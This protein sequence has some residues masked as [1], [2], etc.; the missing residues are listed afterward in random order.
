MAYK[1]N[2]WASLLGLAYR[3][4][5]VVSGEETVVQSVRKSQA[6]LVMLSR[7][8]SDRTTKTI[9]DKCRYYKVPIVFVDDRKSLGEAIG[10]AER[11][12]V[13]VTDPGF[14]EKLREMCESNNRG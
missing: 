1:S 14:G 8:A 4:R 3:A 2:G 10:K 5:K 6:K 13:A 12:V 7:D 11:V 9:T